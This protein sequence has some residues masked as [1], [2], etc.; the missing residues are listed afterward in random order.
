VT[1]RSAPLLDFVLLGIRHEEVR[2][3]RWKWL[4]NAA[5][6]RHRRRMSSSIHRDAIVEPYRPGA[7]VVLLSADR[8]EGR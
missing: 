2:I 8:R 3:F 1:L 4:A 5:A 6:R 7:N